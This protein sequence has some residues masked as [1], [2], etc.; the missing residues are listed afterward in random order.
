[1]SDLLPSAAKQSADVRLICFPHAGAGAANFHR[2]RQ[3]E[4]AWLEILPLQLPGRE[5]RLKEAPITSLEEIVD[6]ITEQVAGLRGNLAL[7]GHSLGAIVA[8]EV[9]RQLRSR[10]GLKPQ[11]LVAA[12]CKPPHQIRSGDEPIYDL[13]DDEFFK[14]LDARYG[15]IPTEIRSEPELLETCLPAMRADV[16]MLEEYIYREAEP[17]DFEILALGGSSDSAVSPT[18]LQSWRQHTTGCFS[19]RMIPGNH[20]FLT[21]APKDRVSPTLSLVLSKLQ[22]YHAARSS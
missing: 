11:F 16:R 1:M 20:F 9:A 4:P 17:F 13:P 15:G 5:T 2:W 18:D 3:A 10:H 12:G 19:A 14:T 22:S 8:F 6:R 21:E 7:L